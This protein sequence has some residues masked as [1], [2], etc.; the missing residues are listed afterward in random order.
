VCAACLLVRTKLDQ[1]A[2][3][4]SMKRVR[5]P[6]HWYQMDRGATLVLGASANV[7]A[8]VTLENGVYA[9]AL[10]NFSLYQ[11]KRRKGTCLSILRFYASP[12]HRCCLR[13][14]LVCDR[15]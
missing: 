10:V 6:R 9:P 5:G 14:C 15:L 12:I 7:H 8:L 2:S 11:L 13:P 3:R 4:R 1:L